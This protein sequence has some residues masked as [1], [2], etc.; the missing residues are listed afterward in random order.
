MRIT[1]DIDDND[2]SKIHKIT[3]IKKRSPAIRQA[4]RDYLDGV[5][6]KRFLQDVLSGKTDYSLTNEDLEATSSYDAP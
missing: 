4:L 6:R 3:G 2:L 1:V 5:R